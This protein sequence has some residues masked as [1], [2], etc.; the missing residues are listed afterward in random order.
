MVEVLIALDAGL[1]EAIRVNVVAV[2]A[3]PL[4]FGVPV[5]DD[6]EEVVQRGGTRTGLPLGLPPL[7][8]V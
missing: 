7:D 3:V 6:G 1:E 4:L 8:A 5:V 2:V